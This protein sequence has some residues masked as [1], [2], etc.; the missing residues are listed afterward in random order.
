M[1]KTAEIVVVGS[2]FFS[3][4]KRDTNSIYLTEELEKRGIRVLSKSVVADDLEELTRVV[5]QG[6][7][8]VD[9][10]ISTG[11]LGPT[12][13]D[14]TREAA[15]RAVG[16]K[17]EY[18]API[19]EEL[20]RRFSRRGRTMSENN[21]RQAYVPAGCSI[22]ANETGTAPGFHCRFRGASFVAL[23]GP[24]REMQAMFG[25]FLESVAEELPTETQVVVRRTLRVSGLGESDMDRRISEFYKDLTNPEVTINFSPHDLEI[26]ITAKAESTE[27]A[28]ELIQPLVTAFRERLDGFL[29]SE[30]DRS[31]AE[32]V[33]EQL[34]DCGS[35][36][37]LAESVTGGQV[38]HS[39][40]SVAG[41]SEVFLGSLVTYTNG[42]KRALL[43]VKE[44]TLEAKSAVSEEVALEMVE[45]LRERTG[46]QI[47]LSCTGYAGPGGGT[48][49]C[50]V[51]TVFVGFST[52]ERTTV[53]RISLPGSRNLI[54]SRATQAMLFLLFRYLR[55]KKESERP[56]SL[57]S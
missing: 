43:G 23:P 17:L 28:E 46:A 12:E 41:A 15:A 47:C 11:G 51:G 30:H 39:L 36:L 44:S 53:R 7:S 2:E 18:Q 21:L 14:R 6:L 24:P 1:Y 56:P 10:V 38:A 19:E 20:K 32:V 16:A 31:L 33:V 4:D 27:A 29:F 13:D 57:S 37:A 35:T 54:R 45:G 42:C 49:E 26:H 8:A 5:K 52:P 25:Q 48:E 34:R 3:R 55:K 40:C 22:L 50:P 9:L